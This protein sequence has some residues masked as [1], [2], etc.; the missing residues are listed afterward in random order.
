MLRKLPPIIL[1][2]ATKGVNL[3]N[4]AL[5]L[6][7]ALE[8]IGRR[9]I[10]LTQIADESKHEL[11][12]SRVE[13]F[14]ATNRWDELLENIITRYDQAVAG[15]NND[16]VV[17][18][19]VDL[20]HEPVYATELNK[21]LT[22]ALDAKVIFVGAHHGFV[23][24]ANTQLKIIQHIF[25]RDMPGREILG[26][27]MHH[28]GQSVTHNDVLDLLNANRA[29]L[30]P[31][32]ERRITPPVFCAELI[33]RAQETQQRI[34]L[35]EGNEPRT[36]K[37]AEIVTKRGIAEC[38]LLGN[39]EQ[40]HQT[41]KENNVSLDKIT[42]IDPAKNYTKYIEPLVELRRS[43]G[44]T[45]EE[46]AKQLQGAVYFGTMMIKL[47]EAD[48]LVSGAIHTTANTVRPALQII[49]TIP[50]CKIVSSIFFM[51]LPDQVLVYG[52]CAI[53]PNPTAA[54]L[55]DIAIQSADSAIA[56]GLPA[57]IA[58]LSYSTGKSGSG[59]DVEKVTQATEL[60]MRLR[61]DLEIESP[62]Q[63]DAAIDKTVASLK[64]PQSKIAG[65]ANV[66]IFPD[67]N[68]G[69]IACKAV[70]RSTNTTCIGPMLQGLNNPINDLSR[71]CSVKD[72]VFTI[73][74]TAVQAITM[75]E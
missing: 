74:L 27:L 49:K 34:V 33:R 45:R 56:F 36:L 1:I 65:K 66:F 30:L 23:S 10:V 5:V 38:I 42:I 25:A 58:M 70:Q 54:E 39:V 37:A 18:L 59:P 16:C 51:C 41:A 60:V 12:F 19:G 63:Y 50:T 52:D 62:I 3:T 57:R 48:G 72:I 35:P 2:P 22:L 40:I 7:S 17:V 21:L 15:Q 31:T 53:N 8:E 64:L 73:A 47:G 55:A 44:L 24:K 46:A 68:S 28:V 6:K 26:S 29:A 4:T 9:P 67:L 20:D 75:K 43:K 61:P 69:N 13:D 71:G 11:S 14:L 32:H